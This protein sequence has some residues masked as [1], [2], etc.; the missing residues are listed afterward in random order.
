MTLRDLMELP[1]I[2]R[3]V[4]KGFS[5]SNIL[6]VFFCVLGHFYNKRKLDHVDYLA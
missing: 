5:C 3:L 4:I 2:S 6:L 1:F